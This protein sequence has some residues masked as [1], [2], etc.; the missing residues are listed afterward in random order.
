MHAWWWTA[1]SLMAIIAALLLAGGKRQSHPPHVARRFIE[2][3]RKEG[4]NVSNRERLENL[5]SKVWLQ[6]KLERFSRTEQE[7][8]QL[9]LVQAGWGEPQLRFYFLA[10]AWL[11]PLAAAAGAAVYALLQGK[12]FIDLPLH[13]IFAFAL[14]FVCM[15][16]FLR[17]RAHSRRMAMR[18]E[19][20]TLLH[21]LRMLFDAGLSLEHTLQVVQKQ[22][23][24]LIPNLAQEL[25][26]ALL[27]IQAGQDRGDALME[28][29]TPLEV[30]ELNDTIV[31]LKQATRYGGNIRDPLVEYTRL[32]EQ[33]QVSELREYVGKLSAKMTVVMVLF[34]FPALMI[35][36][37]GPGFIGLANALKGVGG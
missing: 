23:R 2:V 32:V 15:R 28:M 22:G 13:M 12:A 14:V 4:M 10:A 19:V 30:P 1:V 9:L 3:L 25:S 6:R 17:W 8:M 16:R 31:L 29:A 11:I 18:K 34:L 37:A 21:L 26:L 27:R 7:E 36:V 33:R 20:I 35:F 24:E 5:D